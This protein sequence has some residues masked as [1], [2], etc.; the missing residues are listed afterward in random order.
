[1][2]QVQH[3]QTFFE[4]AG[5]GG[6][7]TSSSMGVWCVHVKVCVWAC[8]YCSE[9]CELWHR[10]KLWGAPRAW[11]PWCGILFTGYFTDYP[12]WSKT[13]QNL[14]CLGSPDAQSQTSLYSNSYALLACVLLSVFRWL[15]LFLRSL[16]LHMKFLIPCKILIIFLEQQP[17]SLLHRC[18][19][20]TM[21]YQTS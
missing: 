3:K 17:T 11:P 20:T 9:L 1:M 8:G 18:S 5:S 6:P 19:L 7:P 2:K 21:P 13:P 16:L 14:L 15:M 12:L 4:R 10:L